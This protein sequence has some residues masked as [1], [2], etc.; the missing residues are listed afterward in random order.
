MH[1]KPKQ[2]SL[3]INGKPVKV[4]CGQMIIPNMEVKEPEVQEEQLENEKENGSTSTC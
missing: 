2:G 3:K 1:S 4:I